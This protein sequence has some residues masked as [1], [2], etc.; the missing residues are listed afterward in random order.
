MSE[1]VLATINARYA[2]T[3]FGLRCLAANLGRWRDH[4]EILEFTLDDRPADIAEAILARKPRLV[5]IGVYVWNAEASRELV[6]IL[7]QVAPE[8]TIVLGGPEV[9]HEI[10]DQEIARL[11]HHVIRGE[12]ES[13]PGALDRAA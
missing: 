7:R 13:A 8:L 12:G 11:A 9:S 6:A 1:I 2:H 4:A 3:A 10:E 5:G